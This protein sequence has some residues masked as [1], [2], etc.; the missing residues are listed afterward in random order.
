MGGPG[1][2]GSV[3]KRLAERMSHLTK[4]EIAEKKAAQAPGAAVVHVPCAD[5]EWHPIALR[6]YESLQESG[7]SQFFEPSDWGV[8]QYI[9]EAMSQS[10]RGHRIP[11]GM[12]QAVMQATTELMCTEG[13][14][15]RLRM[16]LQRPDKNPP[17][18][19]PA[20]AAVR[21]YKKS[22]TG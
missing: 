2:S 9:A 16:E 15:R 11:S 8:A 20:L 19:S 14:R 12:F 21:D 3:P 10:L 6:F 22:L 18:E 7:Q 5:P 17:K 4:A 13:T 1:R